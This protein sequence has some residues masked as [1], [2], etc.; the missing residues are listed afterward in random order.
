VPDPLVLILAVAVIP[1]LDVRQ[2]RVKEDRA[3]TAI[4]ELGLHVDESFR[5]FAGRW[6]NSKR[7]PISDNTIVDYEWRLSYLRRF[8]GRYDLS[9]IDVAGPTSD[10]GG[11]CR[12]RRSTP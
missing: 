11:H 1:I 2:H 12:T 3:A 4:A 6:W 8:F 10:N 5:A 9:R 7:L